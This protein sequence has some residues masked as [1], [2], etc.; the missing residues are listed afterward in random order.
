[1]WIGGETLAIHFLTEAVE[2]GFA[3]AP[4]DEGAGIDARRDVALEV[5]QIAAI[6]VVTGTEEV[7]ECNLIDGGR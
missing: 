1:M 4:F 3:Q 7:V 6:L 2:L 5:D